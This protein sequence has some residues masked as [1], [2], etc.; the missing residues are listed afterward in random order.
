MKRLLTTAAILAALSAPAFALNDNVIT[1]NSGVANQGNLNNST[2][3]NGAGAGGT[4]NTGSTNTNVNSNVAKGGEAFSASSS[5]AKQGQA[6]GQVQGQTAT[7]GVEGSGNSSVAIKDR[8]QAPTVFAPG[9]VAGFDCMGSASVGGSVAGFGISGGSTSVNEDCI[10]VYL[11]R[12]LERKGDKAGSWGVLCESE[13]VRKHSANCPD[14]VEYEAETV[15]VE[16]GT[17]GSV[18]DRR[19]R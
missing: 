18:N 6:Q 19:Y 11:S 17:G 4:F 10:N 5:S 12:E 13:K 2:I 15:G 16:R 3:N 7:S 9:L 14:A 1:G 8:K